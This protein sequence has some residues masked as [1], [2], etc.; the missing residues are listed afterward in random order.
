M[1]LPQ[2][3]QVAFAD[4]IEFFVGTGAE[5]FHR[6]KITNGQASPDIGLVGL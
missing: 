5:E 2:A 4:E 3:R 6:L 1:H